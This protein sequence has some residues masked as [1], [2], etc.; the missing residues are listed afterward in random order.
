MYRHEL[1]G[2]LH[3]LLRVRGMTQDDAHIF[4]SPDQVEEE[5]NGILDLTFYLLTSF[6]FNEFEVMLSTRPEKSVGDPER[7]DL[8]TESLRRTLEKRSLS[9]EVDAGGGAFYGPKID[10]HIR[11][12]IGRLWQCTTVQFDFNLPERFGLTY[13]GEDGNEHQP[14]MVHRALLGA[15][16]RFMGVLIEH[17]GGAF[18]IWLAPVQAVVI[19]IASRHEDYARKVESQLAES[20]IRV[21]TDIRN[22]RMN[23]KIREAQIQKVPYML[24]VG[25]REEEA[26]T[27]AV[28]LRSGEDLGPMPLNQIASRIVL[29][30]EARD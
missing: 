25:D 6:G 18:P 3:G 19:P 7:W 4:C 22:E 9:Y 5:V 24:I 2:V 29:Q 15:L 30:V 17:Y 14:Y 16:E 23:A 26:A 21:H 8:A 28:R 13:I 12:A 11:D 20:S 1:G 10:V 27:A